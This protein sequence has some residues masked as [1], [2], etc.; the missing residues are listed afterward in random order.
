MNISQ[1]VQSSVSTVNPVDFTSIPPPQSQYQQAR[2]S[3]SDEYEYWK[4]KK[5]K[6]LNVMEIL[7][8][9]HKS[10]YNRLFTKE[11]NNL[12][13]II[14]R[15]LKV[16]CTITISKENFYYTVKELTFRLFQDRAEFSEK[17][18]IILYSLFDSNISKIKLRSLYDDRS[19]ES[20]VRSQLRAKIK[21]SKAL[22]RYV[23]IEDLCER[24]ARTFKDK[25]AL[26][27]TKQAQ[28]WQNTGSVLRKTSVSE[29]PIPLLPRKRAVSMLLQSQP[30]SLYPL[31]N[32][33]FATQGFTFSG[34]YL[35]STQVQKITGPL[36]VT[37]KNHKANADTHLS[38]AL[39][40][41][42]YRREL[43]VDRGAPLHIT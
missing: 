25:K 10:K 23:N 24:V 12:R 36:N 20:L 4:R 32:R 41:R 30:N 2:F 42:C 21:G 34:A 37:S 26:Y 16:D 29:K 3:P 15:F 19:E 39:P 8:Q 31:A 5:E 17:S 38:K 7:P 6:I 27:F 9:I 1:I 33:L 22:L 28:A 40:H 43:M 11:K 18:K 14:S 13:T 35:P